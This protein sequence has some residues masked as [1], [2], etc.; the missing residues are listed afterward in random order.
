MSSQD[1]TQL[2]EQISDLNKEI[3]RLKQIND[4]QKQQSADKQIFIDEYEKQLAIKN[5]TIKSLEQE[6][7][8]MQKIIT[9]K[10]KKLEEV[11]A[12]NN[13]SFKNPSR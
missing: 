13:K 8:N 2:H 10:D 1:T 3:S 7:T 6:K 11:K 4:I 5:T 9:E 12:N